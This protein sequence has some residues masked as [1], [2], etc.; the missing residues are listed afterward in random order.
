MMISFY[1]PAAKLHQLQELVKAFNLRF[2]INPYPV[3]RHQPEGNWRVEIDYH[4]ASAEQRKQFDLSWSQLTG[5]IQE[6][7]RN[8]PWHKR[9]KIR[10]KKWWI[11]Q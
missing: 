7:R 6:S 11:R 4:Q 1:C 2:A 5:S 10:F 8:H 9:V 3:I